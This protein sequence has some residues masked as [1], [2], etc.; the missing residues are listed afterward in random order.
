MS[1]QKIV[2]IC[3]FGGEFIQNNDGS[4]SYVDGEAHAMEVDRNMRFD[5]FRSEIAEMW[6]HDISISS[7]KY[8]LPSNKQTLITISN[9]KDLQRMVDF[10]KGLVTACVYILTIGNVPSNI[11]SVGNNRYRSKFV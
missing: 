4:L 1:D 11:L 6:N 2:V 8:F 3:Q 5:D 7:I 10:H 9:D